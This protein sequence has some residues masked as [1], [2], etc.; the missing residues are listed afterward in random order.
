MTDEQIISTYLA[1]EAQENATMRGADCQAIAEGIVRANGLNIS[2]RDVL[3][4]VNE[5]TMTIGG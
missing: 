4:M 5:H 3:R 2:W 1:I